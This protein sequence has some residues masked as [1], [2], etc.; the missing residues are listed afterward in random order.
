[1]IAITVR[2]HKGD[3]PGRNRDTP[4]TEPP[5]Q[6]VS[7]FASRARETP[8]KKIVIDGDRYLTYAQ[9]Y[10]RSSALAK[11]LFSL[12]LKPGDHAAVMTYN[13]LEH[14]IIRTALM[15]IRVS[16]VM[17]GYR[18]KPPEIDHIANNSD[19]KRLIFNQVHPLSCRTKNAIPNCRLIKGFFTP[20]PTF[21][22][23][24]GRRLADVG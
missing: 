14:T 24:M 7:I 5:E 16:L 23:Q 21:P 20:I 1:M 6:P 8:D 12:G 22:R 15:L 10:A 2:D 4:P 17:M 9:A 19:A 13:E 11:H 3:R 18:S